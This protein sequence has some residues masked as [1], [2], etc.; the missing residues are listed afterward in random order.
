MIKQKENAE[1]AP[2]LMHSS[3]SYNFHEFNQL[4]KQSIVQHGAQKLAN[5]RKEK[6]SFH[7]PPSQTEK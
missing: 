4:P 5:A 1:T 2:K 7:E 6:A 3:I